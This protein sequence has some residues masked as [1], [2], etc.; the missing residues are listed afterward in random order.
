M[1]FSGTGLSVAGSFLPMAT[2]TRSEVGFQ[3]GLVTSASTHPSFSGFDPESLTRAFVSFSQAAASLEHSY[4][5]LQAEVT[6]LRQELGDTHRDLDSSLEENRRMRERAK[7]VLDRLP[8]GVLVVAQDTSVSLSNPEAERLLSMRC[9]EIPELLRRHFDQNRDDSELEWHSPTGELRWIA[10]RRT[11]VSLDQG[12]GSIF[13]LQD[14]S[15]RKRLEEEQQKF[16]HRQA[17]ADMSALLAHE[18]RNPLGS[19][20][21]F[22]GLLSESEL[23]DEE[24]HWVEHI[25]AGLRSLTATVNNVL[26]FHSQPKLSQAPLSV[27]EWL[28]WFVQFLRPAAQR[29]NVRLGLVPSPIEVCIAVDRH[30]MEQVLLNLALNSFH[31][32]P[33]GGS[34]QISARLESDPAPPKVIIAVADT[35][36]GIPSAE[37]ERIFE[38][39]F[40]TRSGSPGLGLAVCRTIME[41]HGGSI[42][43]ENSGSPGATFILELPIWKEGHDVE[44]AA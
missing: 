2:Q 30:R 18:I 3:A 36:P 13:I 43:V 22:A 39:G 38:P 23:G 21:L 17:L 41:Q 25:Q 11:D 31:F 29:T 12:Q 24:R 14:I 6:R 26:H 10:I 35:G 37:Q 20:E 40:T 27:N 44:P 5:Q 1:R 16:R 34:L 42:R 28:S 33:Q 32:L 19:L 9:S 15:E 8:C 4:S 7:Q